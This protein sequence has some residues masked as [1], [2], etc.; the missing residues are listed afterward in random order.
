MLGKLFLIEVLYYQVILLSQ[1]SIKVIYI[2]SV[3][4]KKVLFFFQ[5]K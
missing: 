1:T 3:M 2:Y 4:H 5:N